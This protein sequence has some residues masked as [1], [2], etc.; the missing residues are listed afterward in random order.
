LSNFATIWFLD[1][2]P[3]PEVID[4]SE[5]SLRYALDDGRGWAVI[6]EQIHPRQVD[7]PHELRVHPAGM[8]ES[9][10]YRL[11]QSGAELSQDLRGLTFERTQPLEEIFGNGELCLV[12]IDDTQLLGSEWKFE[13][14][15]TMVTIHRGQWLAALCPA[16]NAGWRLA[17][18]NLPS[19]ARR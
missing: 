12:T 4:G 1:G 19:A 6:Q 18:S 11:M 3:A 10:S 5:S 8:F 14:H 17:E 15:Q 16:N 7:V 9:M 2:P 13:Q